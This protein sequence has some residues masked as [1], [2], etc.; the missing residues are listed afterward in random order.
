MFYLVYLYLF[1]FLLHFL[2]THLSE[3]CF[4]YYTNLYLVDYA[5]H[6]DRMSRNEM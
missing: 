4:T 3:P 5:C 1:A 6:Y 2:H